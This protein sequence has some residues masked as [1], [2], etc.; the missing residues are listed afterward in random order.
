MF[1]ILDYNK[2][3]LNYSDFDENDDSLMCNDYLNNLRIIQSNVNST[4]QKMFS[5]K[6]YPS[7][8]L[9][10]TGYA[11][12]IYVVDQGKYK[13]MKPFYLDKFGC[14]DIGF[15]RK[16]ALFLNE[17]RYERVMDE[18]L[19]GEFTNGIKPF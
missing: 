13:I 14:I 2:M 12:S 16:Q 11:S 5:N 4:I 15:A 8:L 18:I 6:N 9:F 7:V 1:N 10:I 19:S 3:I 17:E